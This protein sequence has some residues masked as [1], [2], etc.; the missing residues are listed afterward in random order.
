M[1]DALGA[2]S[3]FLKRDLSKSFTSLSL[4]VWFAHS[5]RNPCYEI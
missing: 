4:S 5:L 1:L 2:T 3:S